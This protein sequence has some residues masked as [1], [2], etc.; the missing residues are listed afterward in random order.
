MAR[1]AKAA[2]FGREELVERFPEAHREPEHEAHH[3]NGGRPGRHGRGLGLRITRYAGRHRGLWGREKPAR[4]GRDSGF[5][6]YGFGS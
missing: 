6:D 1:M 3:V 4:S 2:G 5:K